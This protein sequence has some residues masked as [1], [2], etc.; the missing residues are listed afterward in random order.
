MKKNSSARLTMMKKETPNDEFEVPSHFNEGSEIPGYSPVDPSPGQVGF[1]SLVIYDEQ[2][3]CPYLADQVA[4]MPLRFPMV[5]LSDLQAQELLE[6]GFRRS[7]RFLYETACPKCNAC[8]AIR[9]NVESFQP[10]RSQRRA[11]KKGNSVLD[12]EIGIPMVDKTRV[13][14]FNKHRNLRG[15]NRNGGVVDEEEY[16][17]F[18]V[19][20]CL[21]TFEMA[22]Y[23]DGQLIGVAICDLAENAVSAVYTFFDPEYSHLSPGTY[24]IMKQV[25]FCRDQELQFLYLGY[26]VAGSPHMSYKQRFKP[27][28]RYQRGVWKNFS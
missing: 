9:V 26:F 2:E 25:E 11:L 15:L 21:Q 3:P 27:H 20:S 14:L 5:N 13:R 19:E 24:S 22:Y 17:M 10:N 7:G 23:H 18:L 8:E 16:G 12:M 6:S 28:E 1:E 4:R